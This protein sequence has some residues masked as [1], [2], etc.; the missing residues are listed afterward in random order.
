MAIIRVNMDKRSKGGAPLPDGDYTCEVV[1]AAQGE[2]SQKKSPQLNVTLEVVTPEQYAGSRMVDFLPLSDNAAFRVADFTY[3]CGVDEPGENDVDTAQ[4]CRLDDEGNEVQERGA[5]IGV[6][7]TTADEKDNRD[8]SMRKRVRLF[9]S[10]LESEEAAPEEQ[11]EEAPAPV[12]PKPAIKKAVSA[13]PAKP[14][15]KLS[16][17]A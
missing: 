4:F 5:V 11:A 1:S 16:V 17:K 2:S 8:G 12:A 6:R 7:R 3:A 13:A 9:Y 15:K 14:A 10:R